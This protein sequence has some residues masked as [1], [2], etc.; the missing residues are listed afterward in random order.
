[1]PEFID[2]QAVREYLLDLQQRIVA[3]FEQLDGKPFCA[4][5]WE[6]PPGSPL[7]GGG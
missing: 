4:D 7:G 6:K 2:A 3:R 1:M 5:T